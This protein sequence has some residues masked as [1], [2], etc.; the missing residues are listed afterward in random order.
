M[1]LV[2]RLE[3]A[4]SDPFIGPKLEAYLSKFDDPT[5]AA[6]LRARSFELYSELPVREH[7]V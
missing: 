6:L 5:L 7:C 3:R 2:V 1:S 4:R